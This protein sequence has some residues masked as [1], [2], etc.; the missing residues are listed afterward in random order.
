[1]K[2]GIRPLQPF[3]LPI[4]ALA[5]V[6]DSQGLRD[7][8]IDALRLINEHPRELDE[9]KASRVIVNRNLQTLL[10]YGWKEHI[11]T[12]YG[13]RVRRL[14]K[15]EFVEGDD[16]RKEI[17]SAMWRKWEV[18]HAKRVLVA[19]RSTPA[20]LGGRVTSDSE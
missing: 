2:Y 9:M 1:L 4:V 8:F 20:T 6:K 5:N 18:D 13:D 15:H 10:T 12:T 7:K 19:S 3:S 11:E 14:K 16:Y 17:Y